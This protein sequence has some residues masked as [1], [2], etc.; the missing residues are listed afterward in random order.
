[1][2]TFWEWLSV[3]EIKMIPN[4]ATLDKW[5]PHYV[6]QI[7]DRFFANTARRES[8]WM[9]YNLEYWKTH[10]NE[11]YQQLEPIAQEIFD[12]EPQIT[13]GTLGNRLLDHITRIFQKGP[14]KRR[15]IAYAQSLG[16]HPSEVEPRKIGGYGRPRNSCPAT[17]FP[18]TG[19][20]RNRPATATGWH[21]TF[22]K[23]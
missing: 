13:T 10:R 18:A 22:W 19:S 9:K 21:N 3:N 15:H 1:M 20:S 17:G 16:K 7:I 23:H 12:N 4:Q 14:Y 11:L 2:V 8:S 6:N 5:L